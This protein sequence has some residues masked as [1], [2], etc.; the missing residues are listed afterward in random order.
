MADLLQKAV[1]EKVKAIRFESNSAF[2]V[3]MIE[4]ESGGWMNLYV[5]IPSKL[6]G[7]V[8]F[9]EKDQKSVTEAVE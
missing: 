6:N 7:E 3:Y 9:A 5:E 8:S 4:F 1:G 2:A